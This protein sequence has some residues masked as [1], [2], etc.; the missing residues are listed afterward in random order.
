MFV[1]WKHPCKFLLHHLTWRWWYLRQP[2]N[3]LPKVMSC[4]LRRNNLWPT[5]LSC[6]EIANLVSS[7]FSCVSCVCGFVCLQCMVSPLTT[8]ANLQW[9]HFEKLFTIAWLWIFVYCRFVDISAVG[10]VY[11]CEERSAVQGLKPLLWRDDLSG[12]QTKPNAG[13]FQN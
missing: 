11:F 5:A 13:S 10:F 2:C 1:S 9:L 12:S 7:L 8:L 6:G 3:F 4:E